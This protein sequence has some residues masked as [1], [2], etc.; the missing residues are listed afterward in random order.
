MTTQESNL[1]RV[2]NKK[3]LMIIMTQWFK[4]EEDSNF[5]P[6]SSEIYT[7]DLVRCLEDNFYFFSVNSLD[8]EDGY[9][10]SFEFSYQVVNKFNSNDNYYSKVYLNDIEGSD[11]G[12]LDDN[13]NWIWDMFILARKYYVR[14]K[15]SLNKNYILA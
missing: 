14:I 3:G 1:F 7:N 6:Y 12:N 2:R 13:I 8:S 10:T 4:S 11:I 5:D 15:K 9:D